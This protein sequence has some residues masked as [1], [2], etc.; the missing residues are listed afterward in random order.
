MAERPAHVGDDQVWRQALSPAR[1]APALFLDRD[2]VVVVETG[3]LHEIAKTEL[4]DGAARSIA[5]ANQRGLHVVLV[6]NQSGIGRGYYGWAE[7]NAV[8]EK[9]LADLAGLGARI[10]GVC[11]CP[12]HPQGKGVYRQAD[13][14][15]RKPNPGMLLKAQRLLD[16]D[17]AASWIVGDRVDDIGAGRNAG[18]AGGV[19]VL[20]GFGESHRER[21]AAM[22]SDGY[23]VRTANDI[24]GIRE[25]IP[26]L[27]S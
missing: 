22:D 10:D 3:F 15:D 8:Q 11:A 4:I 9:I 20:T 2:G 1:R 27:A 12:H 18:L 24:D 7:F 26:Q 25:L 16:I 21:A 23:E 13:H 6:T 17:L 5:R 14:P 19:H